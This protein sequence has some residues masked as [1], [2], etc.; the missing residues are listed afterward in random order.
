MSL[1]QIWDEIVQ[2]VVPKVPFE[3]FRIGF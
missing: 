2:D 3:L 1:L